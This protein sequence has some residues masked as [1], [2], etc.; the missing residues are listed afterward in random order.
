M[1]AGHPMLLQPV[2]DATRGPESFPVEPF[3]SQSS[4]FE[5]FG[6]G[7]CS[8]QPNLLAFSSFKSRSSSA[9]C[10]NAAYF[11]NGINVSFC[12]FILVKAKHLPLL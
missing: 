9:S 2:L 11:N 12:E 5:L 1:E 10:R 4:Q 7:L 6:R 8:L 3:P